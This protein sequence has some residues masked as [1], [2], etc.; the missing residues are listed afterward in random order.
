[1]TESTNVA[2]IERS[3]I[4]LLLK[5]SVR[6]LLETAMKTSRIVDFG[7]TSLV[8]FFIILERLMN[9]GLK[10]KCFLASFDSV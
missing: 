7:E 8:N 9:H 5:A 1:M 4:S 3:N 6:S 2:G 10:C